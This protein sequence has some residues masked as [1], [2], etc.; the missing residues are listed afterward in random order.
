MSE[1]TAKPNGSR[2]MNVINGEDKIVKEKVDKFGIEVTGVTVQFSDRKIRDG[3]IA[4]NGDKINRPGDFVLASSPKEKKLDG[5]EMIE[6]NKG[7]VKERKEK[8]KKAE[9]KKK[10]PQTREKDEEKY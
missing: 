5:Q 3:E 2:E 4:D 6:G 7:R 10:K 9:A 8:D 1:G